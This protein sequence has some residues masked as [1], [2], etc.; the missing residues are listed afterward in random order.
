MWVVKKIMMETTTNEI[1][2]P[3]GRITGFVIPVSFIGIFNCFQLRRQFIHMYL[4]FLLQLVVWVFKVVMAM[5]FGMT[6]FFAL[7]AY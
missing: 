4:L 5:L 6:L 3:S 7:I 1:G 2:V